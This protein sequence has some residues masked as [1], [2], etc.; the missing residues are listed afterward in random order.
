MRKRS[1]VVGLLAGAATA[2]AVAVVPSAFADDTAG[3]T[4]KIVGGGDADQTYSFMVS[5]QEGGQHFCG[6]SLVKP[7]LVVT[8]LTLPDKHGLEFIKDLQV[9]FPG[10][11][12]LVLSM[13]DES[14]YAERA[15]RAVQQ[16]EHDAAGRLALGPRA[17]R[18]Q[19]EEPLPGRRVPHGRHQLRLAAADASGEAD[20]VGH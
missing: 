12:T 15:L 7:D 6:G 11:R 13:H 19:D 5:L 20:T 16:L 4:P 8:D 10:T 18:V 3:V 1:L 17:D 2:V 14:L 9:M